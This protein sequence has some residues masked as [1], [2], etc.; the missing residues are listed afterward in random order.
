MERFLNK[1]AIAFDGVMLRAIKEDGVWRPKNLDVRIQL[2]AAQ[3]EG[4][5]SK[6][7]R[8]LTKRFAMFLL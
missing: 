3:M 6:A 4:K 8:A 7:L 2:R 5:G 1:G